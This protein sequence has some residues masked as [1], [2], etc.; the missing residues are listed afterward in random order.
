MASTFR[1]RAAML[2]NVLGEERFNELQL[3]DL[4][5]SMVDQIF[6][7][8]AAKRARKLAQAGGY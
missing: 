3:G 1:D 8:K 5:R 6:P 4:Y 7:K 2:K